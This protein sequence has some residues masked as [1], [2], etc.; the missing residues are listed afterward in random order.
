MNGVK[1]TG[2]PIIL[3]TPDLKL[4]SLTTEDTYDLYPLLSD[5]KSLR[6]LFSPSRTR[7]EARDLVETIASYDRKWVTWFV[8]RAKESGIACGL[9][10]FFGVNYLNNYCSIA[11]VLSPEYRGRGF[12]QQSLK[13]LIDYLF[14]STEINRI[15]AEVEPENTISKSVLNGLGFLREAEC[16]R[17]RL[18][19]AGEYHDVEMYSLL[20]RDWINQNSNNR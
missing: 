17:Q 18:F 12:A 11:Y 9:M 16:L 6:Y 5:E 10:M 7:E 3:E 1:N 14:S 8:V 19:L 2:D 13:A 4:S 20:K 15:E